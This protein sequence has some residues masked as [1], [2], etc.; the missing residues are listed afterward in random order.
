MD[1]SGYSSTNPL[2]RLLLSGYD[3]STLLQQIQ[4]PNT[5]S[6]SKTLY[7]FKPNFLQEPGGGWGENPSGVKGTAESGK[8]EGGLA[9]AMGAASL[10]KRGV[11]LGSMIAGLMGASVPALGIMSGVLSPFSVMSMASSLL[12]GP[13]TMDPAYG[14]QDVQGITD[15]YGAYAGMKAAA[16]NQAQIDS[17]NATRSFGIETPEGPS[18]GKTTPGGWMGASGPPGLSTD[19]GMNREGGTGP[20]GMGGAGMGSGSAGGAGGNDR[21]GSD[22]ARGGV[23]YATSPRTTR[24]GEPSTGGELGIFIPQW[25]SQPGLQGPEAEVKNALMRALMMLRR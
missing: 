5:T 9:T 22:R 8:M 17:Y 4:S 1:L 15:T 25:M 13:Q 2:I 14:L 20:G 19:Y 16:E 11:G 3:I 12:G 23:E 7:P 10:G 21:G 24:W 18:T 6:S